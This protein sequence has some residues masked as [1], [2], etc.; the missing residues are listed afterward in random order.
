MSYRHNAIKALDE[1][2]QTLDNDDYFGLQEQIDTIR[3]Y[4]EEREQ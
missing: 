3:S 2:E 1:I 4:L